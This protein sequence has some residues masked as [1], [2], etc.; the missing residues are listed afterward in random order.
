[1]LF[2]DSES[3]NISQRRDLDEIQSWKGIDENAAT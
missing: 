1:M 3:G 2:I